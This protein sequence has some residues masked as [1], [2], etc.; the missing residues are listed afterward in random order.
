MATFLTTGHI[1]EDLLAVTASSLS[2]LSLSVLSPTIIHVTGTDNQ[3]ITLPNAETLETGIH[4]VVINDSLGQVTVKNFTSV[5]LTILNTGF[6]TEF[7]LDDKTTTAGVWSQV[8]V[9]PS[10]FSDKNLKLL[11]GGIWS[12]TLAT[13]TLMFSADAYIAVAGLSLTD[14]TISA[15]SVVVPTG[16][17][18]YVVINRQTGGSSLTIQTALPVNVP[19]NNNNVLILAYRDGSDIVV[20][21]SFRLIDGQSTE[22]DQGL[23]RQTRSLLGASVTAATN[24]PDWASPLRTIPSASTGIIESVASIDTEIDKFFGQLRLVQSG[25]SL[26]TVTV[27]GSDRTLLT[28]EILSQELGSKSLSFSGASIDFTTGVVLDSTLLPLGLNFTPYSI[29]VGEYFWYGLLIEYTGTTII[30]QATARIRTALASGSSAVAGSAPMP[31]FPSLFNSR[32]LGFVQIHNNAG[33]IQVTTIRQ[34]GVGGSGGSG[35]GG[36]AS[37][38]VIDFTTTTLPFGGGSLVVDGVTLANDDVVLYGNSALNRAYKVSGLG[39]SM[40]F[41]EM[42][43][44]SNGNTVPQLHDAILVKEGTDINCTIWLSDPTLTP[45]WHRLASPSSTVWTGTTAYANPTFDGTLS[46]NDQTLDLALATIDKYFRGLQLRRHLTDPKRVTILASATTKTDLTVLNFTI[47]DRL[48]SFAGAEINFETGNIYA[49]DG[50]TVIGTFSPQVILQNNYY[51][52]AIGFNSQTV[53]SDNTINP[54]ININYSTGSGLSPLLAPKPSL[55]SRYTLGSVVVEGGLGGVGIL[56]ITQAAIVYLGQFTGFTALEDTVAQNTIDIAA[57]Q[58]FINSVPQQQKFDVGPGGQSIFNLTTFTV[59]AS[60]TVFDVDYLIDGRWQT[61]SVTGDFLDGGAVRK[62]STT[63][64][65]TAE[66]VPQGKE[67]IV[68]K[69]TMSGGDPLVDLTGITVNLGFITPHTLGT[70]A[71]PGSSLIIKDKITADIW[72]IEVSDGVLQAVKIN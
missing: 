5:T 38:R 10:L 61:Q 34:L 36:I 46:S 42:A 20:G 57:I 67:F 49:S 56:P 51:W 53:G 12:W 14:N 18:A 24:N 27:T 6:A 58:T 48:M 60:N 21:R 33:V 31:Q 44:F 47:A 54:A 71:R 65:Q 32:P 22:L 19:S 8:S 13:N 25:V 28:G 45:P 66:V 30:G 43:I 23:S 4:F 40:S 72:E 62:N 37:V 9:D 59:N 17:M 52:Y 68:F 1:K 7:Y 11:A 39:V 64:I 41:E 63:Q 70:L 50:I 16:Q 55:T 15:G 2:P 69:R 3:L 29:P 26:D 35:S